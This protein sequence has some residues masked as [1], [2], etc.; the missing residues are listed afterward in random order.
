MNFEIWSTFEA[1]PNL[2][3]VCGEEEKGRR[4]EQTRV[5]ES[6]RPNEW[7]GKASA[8]RADAKKCAIMASE[9]E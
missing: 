1:N 3:S 2:T 8:V 7:A 6:E 9:S 4:A 5:N